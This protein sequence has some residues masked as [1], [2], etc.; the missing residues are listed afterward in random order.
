MSDLNYL[1]LPSGF[2]A[3][4]SEFFNQIEWSPYNP[5]SNSDSDLSALEKDYLD[6][7]ESLR[8]YLVDISESNGDSGELWFGLSA[9]SIPSDQSR[10][11]DICVTGK[12]IWNVALITAIQDFLLSLTHDYAITLHE[13]LDEVIL[14]GSFFFITKSEVKFW[15]RDQKECAEF[16]CGA[17]I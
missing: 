2:S 6:C 9:D 7:H 3:V 14:E 15:F 13:E 5:I 11:I 16:F 4:D 10:H 12:G 1:D 8:C 17:L